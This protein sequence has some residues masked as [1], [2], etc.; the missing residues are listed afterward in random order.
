MDQEQLEIKCNKGFYNCKK[1]KLN[2]EHWY[3]MEEGQEM[4]EYLKNKFKVVRKSKGKVWMR[5]N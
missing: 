2:H 1:T 4:S 3:F 5:S